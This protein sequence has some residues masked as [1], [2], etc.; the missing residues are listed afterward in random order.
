MG[1]IGQNEETTVKT[2]LEPNTS[3]QMSAVNLKI[4]LDQTLRT[5]KMLA[6]TLK[7]QIRELIARETMLKEAITDGRL[8]VTTLTVSTMSQGPRSYIIRDGRWTLCNG[9]IQYPVASQTSSTNLFNGLFSEPR[10]IGREVVTVQDPCVFNSVIKYEVIPSTRAAEYTEEEFLC[11]KPAFNTTLERYMSVTRQIMNDTCKDGVVRSLADTN[12]DCGVRIMSEYSFYPRK[13]SAAA[14][15]PLEYCI[16]QD[17]SCKL[18]VAWHVSNAS[19]E[20]FEFLKNENNFKKYFIK[21]G[22]YI[23]HII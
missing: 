15:L 16:E 9:M 22:P 12:L 20:N 21:S 13:S 11:L 6:D 7:V 5:A 3:N 17:G 18:I 8:G 2:T 4:K 14:T 1:Q 23:E 19:I 10:C